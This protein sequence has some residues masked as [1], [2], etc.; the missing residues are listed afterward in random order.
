M[1]GKGTSPDHILK[2]GVTDKR[3]A[4]IRSVLLKDLHG[5]AQAENSPSSA[6]EAVPCRWHI[7]CSYSEYPVTWPLSACRE[8]GLLHLQDAVP[9]GGGSSSR[10]ARASG[11][12]RCSRPARCPRVTRA[13][14]SDRSRR[15]PGFARNE[16]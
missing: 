10:P 9:H 11:E 1:L 2:P 12:G 14:W 13:P 3:D 6:S 7:I 8:D 15:T 5:K 16:R 4:K